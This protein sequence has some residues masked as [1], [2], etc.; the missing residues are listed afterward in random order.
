MNHRDRISVQ[1]IDFTDGASLDGPLL[2]HILARLRRLEL[3]NQQTF[4]NYIPGT[5]LSSGSTTVF[6][7]GGS[8][9]FEQLQTT[10]A[11][12]FFTVVNASPDTLTLNDGILD[13]INIVPGEGTSILRY[14]DSWV[15][16]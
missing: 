9:V 7:S 6:T 13:V 5:G 1:R 10:I 11:G 16:Y 14:N 8:Y 4:V 3:G 15:C 2:A 12:T